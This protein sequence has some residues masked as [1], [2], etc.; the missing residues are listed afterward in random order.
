VAEVQA[1]PHELEARASVR[2]P[3]RQQPKVVAKLA[4]DRVVV[5]SVAEVVG[6]EPAREPLDAV[7]DVRR[8]TGDEVRAGVDQLRARRRGRRGSVVMFGLMREGDGEVGRLA[9][10]GSSRP[11][12]ARRRSAATSARA[13][14]YSSDDR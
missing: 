1:E 12:A 14:Q 9:R 2:P 6:G 5:Q 8:M 13:R 11:S 3:E 10:C 4:V 7:E